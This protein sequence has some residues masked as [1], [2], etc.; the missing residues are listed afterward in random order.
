VVA[1]IVATHEKSA[2]G[3]STLQRIKVAANRFIF[4]ASSFKMNPDLH[5]GRSQFV[6]RLIRALSFTLP[7]KDLQRHPRCSCFNSCLRPSCMG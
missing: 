5:P 2:A 1:C 4:F 7:R 6:A 3:S